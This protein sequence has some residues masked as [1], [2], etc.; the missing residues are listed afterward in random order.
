MRINLYHHEMK[1][2]AE[3]AEHIKKTADTGNEF[4]G[5]RFYTEAPLM[6]QPGD[7][8]SAAVTLWVPWTRKGGHETWELKQIARKILAFCEDVD[9]QEVARKTAE[10]NRT[11]E[12]N[13]AARG[14]YDDAA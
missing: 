5:F 12:A 14:Q 6:H 8:D 7:D 11:Y 13:A 2:M 9:A 3:R 10:F 4:H 1:F